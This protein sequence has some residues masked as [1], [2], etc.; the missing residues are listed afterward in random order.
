MVFDHQ[1]RYDSEL[2]SFINSTEKTLQAKGDEVWECMQSL[3]NAAGMLQDTCLCLALQVLELLP[4]IPLDISFHTLL[5]MMLVYG[6]ESY[7]SQAW[8]ENEEET[9]SLGEGA[10]ASRILEKKV[11]QQKKRGRSPHRSPS[12][13]CSHTLSMQSSPPSSPSNSPT[14]SRSR[15]ASQLHQWGRSQS[16]SASSVYLCLTEKELH[17]GS[18]GGS[19]DKAGY[20]AGDTSEHEDG[21][22]AG[23]GSAS[24]CSCP[25]DSGSEDGSDGE[26]SN[27]ECSGNDGEESSSENKESGSRS[28][29]GSRRKHPRLNQM[30]HHPRLLGVRP[31]CL[32]DSIYS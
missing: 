12:Q 5:P 13:V 32:A 7:S 30:E 1:L 3:T 4:T 15:S 16:S 11:E 26:V 14:H 9:S 10:K 20:H 21:V 22:S 17:M 19:D 29:S 8:H 27:L 23:R 2:A 31:H 25:D 18:E 28:S 24:E 6:L